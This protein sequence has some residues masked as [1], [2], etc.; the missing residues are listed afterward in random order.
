MPRGWA[1]RHVGTHADPGFDRSS[2]GFQAEGFACTAEGAAV[3]GLDPYSVRT[4]V[5]ARCGTAL[6]GRVDPAARTD[7]ADAD[8]AAAVRP[9]LDGGTPGGAETLDR[10]SRTAPR[11]WHTR[12]GE[13]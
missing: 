4:P 1:G 9:A 10:Q 11:H 12:Q 6:F 2:A 5:A 13:D 8:L 3:E 7:R